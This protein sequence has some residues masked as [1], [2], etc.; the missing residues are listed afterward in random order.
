MNAEREKNS[1]AQRGQRRKDVHFVHSDHLDHPVYSEYPVM[2]KG[3]SVKKMQ[4]A[5][6]MEGNH[7]VERMRG[8]Q[9]EGCNHT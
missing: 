3:D 4:R 7:R 1:R 8:L 2:Q 5:G 9:R 6:S